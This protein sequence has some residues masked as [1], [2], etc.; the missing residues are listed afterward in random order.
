VSSFQPLKVAD[1]VAEH[2]KYKKLAETKFNE[3]FQNNGEKIFFTEFKVLI[4]R[5]VGKDMLKPDE[6]NA[7]I[8][9]LQ[10]FEL[11]AKGLNL[12]NKDLT[13]LWSAMHQAEKGDATKFIRLIDVIV[14]EAISDNKK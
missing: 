6:R 13:S 10:P 12:H 14:A 1:P 11:F 5:L 3:L 9:Q 7:A 8:K 4:M 2:E